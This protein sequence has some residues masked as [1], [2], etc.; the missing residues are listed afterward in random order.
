MPAPEQKTFKS[1]DKFGLEPFA[2]KLRDYLL[3]ESQFV[4]GSFVLSLNSE[5]GS[6]K[7]TFFTC[8]L[9]SLPPSRVHLRSCT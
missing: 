3:T 9:I 7:T 2:D 6:G 4:G 8:G 1:F 5:F